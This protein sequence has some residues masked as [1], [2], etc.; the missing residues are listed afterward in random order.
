M[1]DRVRVCTNGSMGIDCFSG[2]HVAGAS[3]A[4]EPPEMAKPGEVRSSGELEGRDGTGPCARFAH[5]SSTRSLQTAIKIA[6]AR[7]WPEG[8][9]PRRVRSGGG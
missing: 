4:P 3:L 8:D 6:A 9:E 2:H 7:G 5:A 1:D